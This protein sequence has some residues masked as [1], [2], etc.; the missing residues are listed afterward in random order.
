MRHNLGLVL[1]LSF[2]V[3][4]CSVSAMGKTRFTADDLET[5]HATEQSI[6]KCIRDR[7]G[8]EKVCR[9]TAQA[10]ALAAGYSPEKAAFFAGLR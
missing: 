2:L 9:L 3:A 4:A 1:L 6:R 10:A 7:A 5:R 8:T